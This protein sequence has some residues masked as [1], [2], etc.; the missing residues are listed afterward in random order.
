MNHEVGPILQ[1]I[2]LCEVA[3]GAAA[4]L[5]SMR[6]GREGPFS[7]LARLRSWI[8]EA[9]QGAVDLSMTLAVAAAINDAMSHLPVADITDSG[10]RMR[11]LWE[12]FEQPRQSEVLEFCLALYREAAKRRL[13]L[14]A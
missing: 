3:A 12:I 4:D 5:D 13:P 11:S 14:R 8:L 1:L 10:L 9:E 6:R 7:A 2:D